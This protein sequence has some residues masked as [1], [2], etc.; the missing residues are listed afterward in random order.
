MRPCR[1]RRCIDFRGDFDEDN[2]ARLWHR[3]VERYYDT[4]YAQSDQ[5]RALIEAFYRYFS[6]DML[7]AF[8]IT[9]CI[10]QTAEQQKTKISGLKEQSRN[11]Q[12]ALNNHTGR[13]DSFTN[14][15]STYQQQLKRQ[16]GIILAITKHVNQL[17][18]K[19]DAFEESGNPEDDDCKS[20]LA[21]LQNQAD[22]SCG[23]LKKFETYLQELHTKNDTQDQRVDCLI[24]SIEGLHR[25]QTELR[26]KLVDVVDLAARLDR[27]E[28]TVARGDIAQQETINDLYSSLTELQRKIKAQ[29]KKTVEA[30]SIHSRLRVVETTTTKLEK[31]SVEHDK[32]II[33]LRVR[34]NNIRD[35]VRDHDES[36]DKLNNL[37]SRLRQLKHDTH[38]Q[39]ADITSEF[40][41]QSC[42]VRALEASVEKKNDKNSTALG[43]LTR[44]VKKQSEAQEVLNEQ[45]QKGMAGLTMRVAVMQH[46]AGHVVMIEVLRAVS[47]VSLAVAVYVSPPSQRVHASADVGHSL[48]FLSSVASGDETLL[49]SG[50]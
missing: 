36:I 17:Q 43:S 38:D 25:G 10:L 45:M 46:S 47:L 48:C 37:P 26:A 42:R 2:D 20:Q 34:Q 16:E 28:D 7:T 18:S 21:E 24:T 11:H 1:C 5:A 44:R 40:D 6:D 9:Y 15:L 33:H 22:Q 8:N 29:G 50:L 41:S 49:R 4:F 30:S 3:T 13:L 27:N 31:T 19:L 12:A 23:T 14:S 32:Q 35:T 39:Q